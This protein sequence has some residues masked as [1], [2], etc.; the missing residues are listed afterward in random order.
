MLSLCL[1]QWRKRESVWLF[2]KKAEARVLFRPSALHTFPFV[3]QALHPFVSAVREAIGCLLLLRFNSNLL[4]GGELKLRKRKSITYFI[5]IGICLN[6]SFLPPPGQEPAWCRRLHQ[7]S[8]ITCMTELLFPDSKPFVWIYIL[9]K[10]LLRT[11]THSVPQ[12]PLTAAVFYPKLQPL[13]RAEVPVRS[14]W[15]WESRVSNFFLAL[16]VFILVRFHYSA[17]LLTVKRKKQKKPKGA[18]SHK[19]SSYLCNLL[20]AVPASISKDSLLEGFFQIVKSCLDRLTYR[21]KA[22]SK[23]PAQC[24]RKV[25]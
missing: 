3:T 15:K 22:A 11:A 7:T 9:S 8:Q 16:Q 24:K 10:A 18:T 2:L 14:L 23:S 5:S 1:N 21:E 12:D 25:I 17:Q 19:S 6:L 4:G 13:G 20:H